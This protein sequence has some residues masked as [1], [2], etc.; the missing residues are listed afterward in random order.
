MRTSKGGL[1][2]SIWVK[3]CGIQDMKAGVAAAEGGAQA[4]G[5]VFAPSRRQV[6]EERA[7]A[8]IEGL[9]IATA[10]V[11]VF[12]DE[13]PE[14]MERIA[15]FVGLT[16]IQMHGNEPPEAISQVSFPVIKAFRI[17]GAEDLAILPAYR[18]AAGLLLDPYV[19]G[20]PGG[21]GQT[22][23]WALL[24]EAEAVLT[25][26]GVPLSGPSEPLIAGRPKLI[27]AGGLT[28]VNVG[29]A[30]AEAQPGGIDV[31]SGVEFDGTKSVNLIYAFIETAQ[32]G[33]TTR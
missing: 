2:M 21:T 25:K 12:V 5:F 16:H 20:Q 31:S 13:T 24:R 8:L 11:G 15:R 19:P 30:I 1:S 4:V 9:P 26:A 17:K 22:L 10:K 29:Q 28:S 3:I 32:Q 14:E 23:N 18:Q 7:Q 33:G 6:T 27:L